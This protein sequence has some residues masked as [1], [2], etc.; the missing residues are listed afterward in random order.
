M[1]FD[2]IKERL[3]GL[4]GR[5][6][7]DE[8][9]RAV[10]EEIESGKMDPVAQARSIEDGEA[11]DVKIRA[12]YIKHRVR[13]IKDEISA[14][15]KIEREIEDARLREE[16]AHDRE[17]KER[18]W[19]IRR[20]RYFVFLKVFAIVSLMMSFVGGY[21]AFMEKARQKE[22]IARLGVLEEARRLC[23]TIA[24]RFYNF[25]SLGNELIVSSDLTAASLRLWDL[26]EPS[27][28]RVSFLCEYSA[29]MD[30]VS[31][32]GTEGVVGSKSWYGS[33]LR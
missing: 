22:E 13:R 17:I 10:W 27:N 16:I 14:S 33:Q 28:D 20:S 5:L 31:A 26:I 23:S 29:E 19:Q 3:K 24:L 21:W 9:Y 2:D 18:E 4:E 7:E 6:I 11:E 30:F 12:A 25:D 32:K 8:I 15:T 1:Q